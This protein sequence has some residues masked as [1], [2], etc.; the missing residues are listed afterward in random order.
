METSTD[1][2]IQ[3]F[4]LVGKAFESLEDQDA[5]QRVLQWAMKKYDIPATTVAT[6]ASSASPPATAVQPVVSE[7]PEDSGKTKRVRGAKADKPVL[8]HNLKLDSAGDAVPPLRDFFASKFPG[9][10][11]SHP[12][13]FAVIA[14]WLGEGQGVK[15]LGIDEMYTCYR[16]LKLKMP[17][18]WAQAF[19]D[20][21]SKFGYFDDGSEKGQYQLTHIGE[22]AVRQGDLGKGGIIIAAGADEKAEDA[23]ASEHAD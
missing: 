16:W 6:T 14:F 12:A 18:V 20:G 11:A 10:K 13:A 4:S 7:L 3:A 2:E 22:D 5:R 19:R 9:G 8:K 1:P 15:S 23:D 17:K 21:K